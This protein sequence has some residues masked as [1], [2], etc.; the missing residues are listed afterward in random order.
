[1]EKN[2]GSVDKAIRIVVAIALLSLLFLLEGN[3]RW[4]GLLGIGPLLTVVSGWCPAYT[5]IGIST[6]KTKQS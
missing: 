4:W 3:A 5:L 6:G 2:I 1:M